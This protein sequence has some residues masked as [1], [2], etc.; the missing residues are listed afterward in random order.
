[1]V[2]RAA[3]HM[4]TLKRAMNARASTQKLPITLKMKNLKNWELQKNVTLQ[5]IVA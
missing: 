3:N 1:M 4:C 5:L 2:L